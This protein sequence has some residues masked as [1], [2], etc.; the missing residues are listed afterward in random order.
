MLFVYF[1]VIGSIFTRYRATRLRYSPNLVANIDE[2][3]I[4][5]RLL[6]V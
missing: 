5:L 3:R 4:N 2:K 1:I 6:F